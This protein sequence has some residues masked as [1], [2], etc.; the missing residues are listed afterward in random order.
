MY[1]FGCD[2]FRQVCPKYCKIYI[3]QVI[4]FHEYNNIT[5]KQIVGAVK[6]H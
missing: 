1:I 3:I 2:F 6:L 4:D 5:V